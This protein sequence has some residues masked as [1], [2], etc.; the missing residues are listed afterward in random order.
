VKKLGLGQNSP[1]S[2]ADGLSSP[3]GPDGNDDLFK[4]NIPIA[5]F[6]TGLMAHRHRMLRK[7]LSHSA[8]VR[9]EV[10]QHL[11]VQGESEG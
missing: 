3:F 4:V 9:A 6:A 1:G 5:V 11:L 2:C 8:G 7:R 10:L